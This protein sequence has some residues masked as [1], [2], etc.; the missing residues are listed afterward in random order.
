MSGRS[1]AIVTACV[2]L[3]LA[4]VITSLVMAFAVGAAYAVLPFVGACYC[5]LLAMFVVMYGDKEA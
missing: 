3:S 1:D 2:L 5:V 4:L